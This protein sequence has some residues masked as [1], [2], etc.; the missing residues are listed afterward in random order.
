[1]STVDDDVPSDYDTDDLQPTEQQV[2]VDTDSEDAIIRDQLKRELLLLA[3][4]TKR[5]EFATNEEKDIIID[6]VTQLEALNPSADPAS[7]CTGDWDLVLTSTQAFRSSP[8]FQSI[9]ALFSDDNKDISENAFDLHNR[10]TAVG[11]IGRVR[12]SIDSSTLVSE[13]DLEVGLMGGMPFRI[14]GTVVTS[15]ELDI[16]SPEGWNM[17][18]LGTRVKG[19]NVP[20]LDQLL[21]DYPVEVPVGD[22][23]GQIM[24]KVPVIVLKTFYVDE[25]IRITRDV[26][27]NFYVFSRT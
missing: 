8:F 4:V 22:I 26:D 6:L 24:G 25:G 15:A 3:S 16:V 9:R 18:V 11:R 5:G 20:F 19:S 17:K 23:Y 21:D 13:V 14:K 12:Q 10:A 2:F 7:Q 1:M 27:N